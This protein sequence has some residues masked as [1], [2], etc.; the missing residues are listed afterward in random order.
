[1]SLALAVHGGAWN[2]PDGD[3]EAHRAGV[4]EAL[5]RGWSLLEEGSPALDVVEAV[6]RTLENDPTF[7]AGRG[8]HLGA[9][10]E[11]GG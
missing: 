11:M 5:A 2:V 1:M 3:V 6:V 8:A 9:A 7:N 4:A 10:I